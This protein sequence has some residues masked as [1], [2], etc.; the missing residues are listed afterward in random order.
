MILLTSKDCVPC[1]VVKEHLN[2]LMH[3]SIMD[4]DSP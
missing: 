3:I 4:I 2:P 1:Q